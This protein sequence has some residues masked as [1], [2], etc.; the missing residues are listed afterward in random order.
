ML[1][2]NNL[3]PY[4]LYRKKNVCFNNYFVIKEYDILGMTLKFIAPLTLI[5]M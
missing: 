3:I 2:L 4:L 1:K 5:G